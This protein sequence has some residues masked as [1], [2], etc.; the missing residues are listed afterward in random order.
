MILTDA[1]IDSLIHGRDTV[2][3]W[4]RSVSG[5]EFPLPHLACQQGPRGSIGPAGRAVS[6]AQRATNSTESIAD[7]A[8]EEGFSDTSA[9]TPQEQRARVVALRGL[10]QARVGEFELAR[11]TFIEA[12]DLDPRLDLSR[13]PSFW[14]LPRQAHD[15]VISALYETERSRDAACLIAGLRTTYRP[16]LLPGFR[17]R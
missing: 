2:I 17:K 13:L 6:L 10:S 12:I 9:L 5:L 14:K 15:A 11:E 1:G 16:R 3:S 4:L 7:S 8:K